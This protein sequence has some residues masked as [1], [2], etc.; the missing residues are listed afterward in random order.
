MRVNF[1]QRRRARLLIK[2]AQP[3][4]DEPL[5]AVA[6]VTW[7]GNSTRSTPGAPGREDLAGGLPMW[8]LIGVGATRLFIVEADH[9]DPD[10]AVALVG[11]WSLDRVGMSEEGLE[12]S[13]GSA[14]LGAYRAIRIEFPDRADAV[15]QPI[16]REVE[17]L[18]AAH[19]AAQPNTPRA[20]GLTEV[21]LVTTAS[22]P[23]DEDVHFVLTY[24][25]G[26]TK[27]VSLGESHDLLTELQALP[28]FDNDTFVRAMAATDQGMAVLWRL[29]SG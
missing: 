27:S 16:G 19:R 23:F 14:K 21:A 11:S 17:E 2:R 28:G 4:A 18:L 22:G 3:F 20:D 6:N 29:N 24:V 25:D 10:R 13:I 8:T 15:L 9:A 1:L 12:R 5:V 26:T 7:V